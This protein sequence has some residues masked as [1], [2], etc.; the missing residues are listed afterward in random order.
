MKAE[1]GEKGSN[2]TK[3]RHFRLHSFS[4]DCDPKWLLVCLMVLVSH[5]TDSNL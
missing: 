2:I 1:G 4:R 3:R 5:K